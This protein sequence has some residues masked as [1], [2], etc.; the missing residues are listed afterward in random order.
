MSSG[1]DLVWF[2]R[3]LRLAD[4]PALT[5]ALAGG[6]PIVPV[7]ILDS[8]TEATGAAARWRLGL[9]IAA[10]DARLRAMG[11]RLIL[12]R[13]DAGEV[14]AQLA[15]ETGAAA[16]HWSRLYAP[17][18]VARDAAVKAGLRDAGIAATSHPGH[19]LHEPWEVVTARAVPS[20]YSRHS[21]TRW[22]RAS[23]PLH[24]RRQPRFRSL[25]LGPIRSGC[26][27]GGWKRA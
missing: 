10:L 6:R 19:L 21:G 26:P 17:D 16:V 20:R 5:A 4:H 15:R 18:T 2:R 12:R 3:D 27:T 22:G 14:L 13:G 25:P 7:F 11:S 23:C 9:A 1:P 8:E 24:S